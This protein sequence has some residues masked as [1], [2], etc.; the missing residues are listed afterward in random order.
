[1]TNAKRLLVT[2]SSGMLGV[3]FCSELSR[4]YKITGFDLKEPPFKIEGVFDFLKIDLTDE[5][6]L[7]REIKGIS[8][9]FVIHLAANTDVDG[10][11]LD[12]QKAYLYN[13]ETAKYIAEICRNNKTPLLFISTDFVFDGNN[14]RPYIETDETNPI[15]VYGKSKLKGEEYIAEICDKY[16][17]FRTAWLYG[18]WGRNFVKTIAA[19]AKTEKMLKIVDDQQGCPTYTKDLTFALAGFLKK[20]LLEGKHC[21]SGIFHLVNSGSCS[22]HEYAKIIVEWTKASAEVIPILSEELNR[23]ARRPKWSVLDCTKFEEFSGLKL[24]NWRQALKSYL[25]EEGFF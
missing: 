10:C 6:R 22:W 4:D 19:K 12:A 2:G 17:I 9:A 15:S 11:E 8:P 3:D 23:P 25:K 21:D 5:N 7:A 16:Y 18:K 24:R 14:N 1:M 13:S 20:L